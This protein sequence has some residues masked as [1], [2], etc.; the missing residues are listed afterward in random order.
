MLRLLQPVESSWEKMAD[1]LLRNEL[2]YK[3]DTIN[4]DCFH[5]GASKN[6]L[7]E[8]CRKWLKCTERVNRTWQTLSDTAKNHKDETLEKFIQENDNLQ[9]KFHYVNRS[10]KVNALVGTIKDHLY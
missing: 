3:V 7:D 10:M 2:Q 1:N 8:V 5:D 4:S 9:S 6:A